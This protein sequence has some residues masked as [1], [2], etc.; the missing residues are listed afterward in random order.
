MAEFFLGWP[1]TLFDSESM[2]KNNLLVVVEK[3][4][5]TK[6]NSRNTY[7]YISFA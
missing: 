1:S 6:R 4:D 5:S 7:S 2:E 3:W